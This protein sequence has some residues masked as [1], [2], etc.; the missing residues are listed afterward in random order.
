M[1]L[2]PAFTLAP[3]SVLARSFAGQL[4]ILRSH[5]RV[6]PSLVVATLR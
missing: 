2:F 1:P 5:A 6:P 4:E 3:R